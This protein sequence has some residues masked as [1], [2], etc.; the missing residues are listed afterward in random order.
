MQTRSKEYQTLLDAVLARSDTGIPFDLLVTLVAQHVNPDRAAHYRLSRL[1]RTPSETAAETI[2][3]GQAAIARKYIDHA[4]RAARI[5]YLIRP[6]QPRLVFPGDPP[7][8]GG[9][10][11]RARTWNETRSN[12]PISPEPRLEG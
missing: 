2:W 9:R 11:P 1:K 5:T 10:Y 3:K 7:T 8:T 12:P 4:H 6:N